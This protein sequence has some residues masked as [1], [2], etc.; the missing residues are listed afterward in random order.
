MAAPPF[1]DDDLSSATDDDALSPDDDGVE[2]LAAGAPDACL[3]ALGTK[4]TCVRALPRLRER[5]KNIYISCVSLQ[6]I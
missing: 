1:D 6:K 3:T 2:G 5:E 4:E